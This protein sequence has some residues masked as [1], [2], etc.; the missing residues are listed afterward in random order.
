M[1]FCWKYSSSVEQWKNF[2]NRLIFEKVIAKSLVASFFGTQCI[3]PLSLSLVNDYDIGCHDVI[4]VQDLTNMPSIL[5]VVIV[6]RWCQDHNLLLVETDHHLL[7]VNLMRERE[8]MP[9]FVWHSLLLLLLQ[10]WM[11]RWGS[12]E[13]VGLGIAGVHCVARLD[14]RGSVEFVGLGTAGV[15]CVARLEVQES[16]VTNTIHCKHVYNCTNWNI[17]VVRFVAEFCRLSCSACLA[18]STSPINV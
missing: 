12:V 14:R 2:E 7:L 10:S 3:V 18:S 13:F 9:R 1:Q 5:L 8:P 6:C 4:W 15:H 17:R 16:N 11:N